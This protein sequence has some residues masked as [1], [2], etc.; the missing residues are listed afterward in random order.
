MPC[1]GIVAQARAW[2]N[3]GPAARNWRR[4]PAAAG[5]RCRTRAHRKDR[6]YPLACLIAIVLRVHRRREWLTA[7]GQWV[8]RAGQA[9]L[10]AAR[11]GTRSPGNGYRMRRRFGRAGLPRAA[12]PG[13]GAAGAACAAAPSRRVRP[14]RAEPCPVRRP[15][16]QDAGP[17]PGCGPWRWARTPS[18]C[19]ARAPRRQHPG[20]PA[21]RRR[22]WRTPAG[23][24]LGGRGQAQRDQPLHRAPGTFG[25]GRRRGDIRRLHSAGEPGL[26]WSRTRT[27][28][29]SRSSATSRCCMPEVRA[30]PWR[31][32]A[33]SITRDTGMAASRPWTDTCM[34]AAW[35]SP[36]PARP[37]RSAGGGRTPLPARPAARPSTPSPA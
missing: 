5:R 28:I 29:S 25:P 8:R 34:S 12:G 36:A 22:A 18:A 31:Q 20:P 19:S 11:P 21:R 3:P 37:S 35:T 14:A 7:V 30:L 1:S 4:R 13:R 24:H 6:I 10:A 9:D 15:A 2:S 33:G 26:G 32:V 23:P 17:G 27:R 16:G